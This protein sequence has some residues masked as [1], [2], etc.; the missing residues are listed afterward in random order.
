[1]KLI[2]T[3]NGCQSRFQA[4][5]ALAGKRGKCPKCGAIVQ[6]PAAQPTASQTPAAQQSPTP[7]ASQQVTAQQAPT[8]QTAQ[9]PSSAS[10]ARPEAKA[11][12]PSQRPGLLDQVLQSPASAAPAEPAEPQESRPKG[13]K[14]GKGVDVSTI[15]VGAAG[16][17][18]LSSKL[19]SRQWGSGGDE[20]GAWSA[21]E[22]RPD[23]VAFQKQVLKSFRGPIAAVELDSSYRAGM[24]AA[25]IV[26]GL[27]VLAYFGVIGLTIWA[28]IYHVMYNM[29]G[30]GLVWL[31]ISAIPLVAGVVLL[32]FLL[33]PI[34]ASW[35]SADESRTM[36][37][38]NE[39]LLFQFV[40]KICDLVGSP[41]PTQVVVNCEVNA[42]ASFHHGLSSIMSDELTLTI[43]MP[44]VA[45]MTMQQ[46]AGVLAHEFGHFTQGAG[47]R[48]VY[49]IR[50][51]N[52]WLAR[53]V[54]ERDDWDDWLERQSRGDFK[55]FFFAARALVWLVRKPYWVLLMLGNFVT[56]YV[57][58]QM[59]RDA[60]R[61]EIRLAG[62]Q[63]FQDTTWRLN[64]LMA[65]HQWALSDLGQF[66]RDGK[67]ADD[68]PEL[69]MANVHQLPKKLLRHIEDV[70]NNGE[71]SVFDSHP[72]DAER[73]D[74][75]LEEN[76]PG[77]FHLE[78]PARLLFIHYQK[79]CQFTTNDIYRRVFGDEFDPKDVYPVHELV[80]NQQVE[81]QQTDALHR[82][83][84]GIYTPMRALQL[85][86]W[87]LGPPAD[88]HAYVNRVNERRQQLVT[89]A[90]NMRS[91]YSDFREQ[92]KIYR[93]TLQVAAVLAA[94][95]R[96]DADEFSFRVSRRAEVEQTQRTAGD[97]ARTLG[98][99]L[100]PFE[101]AIGE[102]LWASLCLLHTPQVQ[103]QL[104][105]ASA[106]AAEA[107]RMLRALRCMSAAHTNVLNL[108]NAYARLGAL[109]SYLD[110]GNEKLY[111]AIKT[112]LDQT[113][114]L[115]T[116]VRNA[117]LTTEY[118]LEHT[119]GAMTVGEYL[120]RTMP[121]SDELGATFEA[122]QTV[123][124]NFITTYAR[125]AGRVVALAEHVEQACSM[126]PLP[127]PPKMDMFD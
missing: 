39:P 111:R 47:M 45:G 116:Q 65:A 127:T 99:Q 17:A 7:Q 107:Q 1:M 4:P 124:D 92:E 86:N 88:A 103:A 40:D 10:P 110:N 2:V 113:H 114:G 89:H 112:T 25:L 96:V 51:L 28:I 21:R 81:N 58:R 122:A 85:P 80:A 84:Q 74:L 102:R 93:Q 11:A 38:E 37:R 52:M 42:S 68:L 87:E 76:D 14:K 115:I 48:M 109:C 121:A 6:V 119:Q 72:A 62:T 23:D 61:H 30:G 27:L 46:F 77:V 56:G 63:A 95:F 18:A 55:S 44:L 64:V 70:M 98:A 13:A 22:P 31:W 78:H 66:S 20:E 36:T 97:K 59:E 12:E 82:F 32:I 125:L 90:E 54:Y 33:K 26:M 53:V 101:A 24:V 100:A 75:A 16:F 5:A 3:C 83:T 49:M 123:L 105:E 50:H 91:I 120:L 71:T 104:P 117:C 126:P 69:I 34:V 9:R 19:T 118:P 43:G 41:T 67:L 73:I 15:E 8:Q 79:W 29:L 35:S 106:R 94:G 108:R 60:D 57:L